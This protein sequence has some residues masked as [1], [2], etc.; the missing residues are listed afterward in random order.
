MPDVLAAAGE[1]GNVGRQLRRRD[2]TAGST[3]CAAVAACAAV[4][5]LGRVVRQ[6]R[7]RRVVG[8]GRQDL[9]V[10]P[11][12]FGS[13]IHAKLRGDRLACLLVRF[14][15]LGL[16]ARGVQRPH[17]QGPQ[18]LVHRVVGDQAAQA[19]HH[20]GRPA[21][22]ELGFDPQPFRR[23][24][25]LLQPISLGLD[26]GRGRHVGKWLAAPQRRAPR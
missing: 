3:A 24:A 26:Q 12:Q 13:G 1:V 5:G 20:A 15:R 7:Q 2:G 23:D 25:G 19:R 9:L 21:A 14:E 17:Q 4:G 8:V 6:R 11:L 10:Q 22:R 18:F 16:A